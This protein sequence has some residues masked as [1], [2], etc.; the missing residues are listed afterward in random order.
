MQI[1]GNIITM[2]IEHT[3]VGSLP[4]ITLVKQ[5]NGVKTSNELVIVM[6]SLSLKVKE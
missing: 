1:P 6:T 2:R 3:S 4:D 5:G